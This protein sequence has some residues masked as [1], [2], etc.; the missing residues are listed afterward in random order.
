[1]QIELGVLQKPEHYYCVHALGLPPY[2][3]LNSEYQCTDTF[4]KS[5]KFLGWKTQSN[6]FS[7]CLVSTCLVLVTSLFLFHGM[8][9]IL[10]GHGP[11]ELTYNTSLQNHVSL[12]P[13]LGSLNM[14]D[15]SE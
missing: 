9:A 13:L 3:H 11:V 5:V 14:S 12:V 2:P 4:A 1:M 10:S 6:F 15:W 7:M 8:S